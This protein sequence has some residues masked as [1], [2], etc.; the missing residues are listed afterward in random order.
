MEAAR[1]SVAAEQ[2]A[3]LAA[4]PA[5][6]VVHDRAVGVHQ[7]I[8]VV[9]ILNAIVIRA[10][11]LLLVVGSA[12]GTALGRRSLRCFLRRLGRLFGGELG[13]LLLG[14]RWLGFGAREVSALLATPQWRS[15]R[16]SILGRL[17]LRAHVFLVCL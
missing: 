10:L 15:A 12:A 6:V 16:V 7:L 17:S 2:L 11:L 8:V 13:C 3:A 1:A 9:L 4:H 14:R 5:L